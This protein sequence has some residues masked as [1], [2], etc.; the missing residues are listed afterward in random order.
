MIPLI[1]LS[2]DKKTKQ[3]I[4]AAISKVLESKNYILGARLES[5]EKKFAEYLGVKYAI[6]VGNGTDAL[7]LALRVLGVGKGDSVLTVSMTS[8]FTAIAII[9]EGSRPIFCDIDTKT[10]TLDINDALRKLTRDTKAIIPVHIYGNP[11][12]LDRLRLFA[13]EH[14]LIIIEDSCQ[15]IGATFKGKKV[16]TFGNAAAFSFYPTKNLGG[17][18]DGGIM[19]TN[20]KKTAKMAKLLRHG[21]QTKRFWHVHRGFNSRLD[22][23]QAAILEV[24]LKTIDASNKKR[25]VISKKYIEDLNGLPL[26]F[27]EVLPLAQSANHIFIIRTKNRNGLKKFLHKHGVMSDIYYPFPLHMQPAFNMFYSKLPNTERISKEILAL[28]LHPNLAVKDQDK[29]IETIK[30]YFK[31]NA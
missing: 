5:F 12:N 26:D 24:K 10:L 6:G 1:D 27:Q 30:I 13:K 21:G 4:K 16:G 28:P 9:E 7:R 31:K 18:G 29:V 14:N 8:P 20:N 2:L 15:A 22:E 3:T 17:I 11:A 23:I 25:A 19:V